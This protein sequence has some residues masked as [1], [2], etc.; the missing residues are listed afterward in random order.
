LNIFR[1]DNGYKDGS[2]QKVWDG[3][4]DNEHLADVLATLDC[5]SASFK[6]DIYLAL[7][8]IYSSQCAA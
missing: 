2:Y 7:N 3:R 6:K 4:E 8:E 1:Q 5:D